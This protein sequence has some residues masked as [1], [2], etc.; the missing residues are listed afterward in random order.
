MRKQ[1]SI[2]KAFIMAFKLS[3][4]YRNLQFSPILSFHNL[5]IFSYSNYVFKRY[6]MLYEFPLQKKPLLLTL[7]SFITSNFLSSIKSYKSKI[8]IR[9]NLGNYAL[10]SLANIINNA[11]LMFQCSFDDR[12]WMGDLSKIPMWRLYGISNCYCRTT[13]PIVHIFDPTY[14]GVFNCSYFWRLHLTFY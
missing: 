2:I 12:L 9:I 14:K 5:R 6:L 10:F 8:S 7:L 1:Q 13:W 4:I 11:L 3:K